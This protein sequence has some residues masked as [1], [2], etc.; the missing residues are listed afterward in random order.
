[1]KEVRKGRVASYL[2]IGALCL[3]SNAA[4]AAPIVIPLPIVGPVRINLSPLLP[5]NVH[6]DTNLALPGLLA[7][8]GKLLDIAGPTGIP[9]GVIRDLDVYVEGN[10]LINIHN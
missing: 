2:G 3:L 1:M 10:H 4:V 6:V 8:N 5:V 9:N 7:V